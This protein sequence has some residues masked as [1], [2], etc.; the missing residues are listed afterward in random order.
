[1]HVLVTGATG[2]VGSKLCRE[3]LKKGY[4]V[5]GLS[6]K[7]KSPEFLSDQYNRE[8][9]LI[10]CNIIQDDLIKIVENLPSIDCIF[11]LA[12]Q[13]YLKD[14]SSPQIY[15]QNNFVG[16]LN[17]LEC[18][19]V[20]KIPKFVFSSSMAAYGL[21][22]GQLKPSYLPVDEKHDVNPY[23]FYDMSKYQAEQLC[24]YYY[25]RVGVVSIVLR[26]SR[27]YG[28]GMKK[29]LVFLAT[30]R[31]LGN[32]PIV[33]LGD[34]ST[35]FVFIDDVINANLASLEKINRYEIYNIGSGE[36][37]TLF[38]LCS[39]IVE[40][41]DSSSQLNFHTKPKSR[42]SLDISKAQRELDYQSTSMD[43][44]LKK[45]VEYIKHK[46]AH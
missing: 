37:M 13:T 19:R 45:Y 3:L 11:H 39:K 20:L 24:K 41:C 26:Y 5:T 4:K 27:I 30:K 29:G 46:R 9:Q 31:A 16:T 28:P 15:F 25:D 38:D 1:M 35:D 6:L 10:N 12:G 36:E 21:G 7:Q 33:V 42:F 32:E 23:D 2:F 17:V 14:S 22:V 43:K 18:C 44:G 8:F 40:L 34:V